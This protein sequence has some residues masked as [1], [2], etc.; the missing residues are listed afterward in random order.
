M[1]QE[2]NKPF[3]FDVAPVQETPV[4]AEPKRSKSMSVSGFAENALQDAYDQL[5]GIFQLVPTIVGEGVSIGKDAKWLSKVK[6]EGVGEGVKESGKAMGK[7]I[8]EPYETHGLRVLYEK[9][10]TAVSDALAVWG[11]TAKSA[12]LAGRMAGGVV[13]AKPLTLADKVVTMAKTIEELPSTLARKGIDKGVLKAS[14]GKWD[15]AKRREFLHLKAEEMAQ[16]PLKIKAD[17]ENVGKAIEALDDGEAALFHKWRVQGAPAADVAANPK[18]GQALESWRGLVTEFQEHLKKRGLLNDAQIAH[19]LEKK[20]AAEVFS[21]ID[22]ATLAE[23]RAAITKAE[24]KPVYGPSL[25]DKKGW[26][27]DDYVDEILDAQKKNKGGAVGFLEEYKGKEGSIMDPRKYIPKHIATFRHV[28]GKLRFRDRLLQTPEL[29]GAPKGTKPMEGAAPPGDISKRY[30][31]DQLRWE[32]ASEKFTDPTIKRL[33]QLEANHPQG[34][35]RSFLRVYD[36]I[37]D[38]FRKSATVMNPRW[39]LGNAVG[40]AV[41]GTLAGSEWRQAQKLAARGSLP[42]Q[43]AAKIGPSGDVSGAG[44]FLEKASEIGNSADQATKAGVVT[45]HVAQKLKETGVSAEASFETLENVLKSTQQF[46]DVQVEMQLLQEQIARGSDKVRRVNAVIDNYAKKHDDAI[47]RA[48]NAGRKGDKALMEQIHAEDIQPL[49]QKIENLQAFKDAMVRDVADDLAKQGVL[50]AKIPGLREQNA[51]VREAVERANAFLGDYLALDGFEQGVMRRLIPFY[52]WSKA[53]TMLAFRLPF[54]APVKGFLWN[55][56]S[57]AMWSMVGDPELPEWMHGSVP[58]FARENGDQVWLKLSS[59]SPFSGLRVSKVGGV[60]V[61][62]A[63]NLAESSPLFSVMFKTHGGKTVFDKGTMPYAGED[64]IFM[65]DGTAFQWNG[66]GGVEK[67]I[68]QAPLISSLAH[69]FPIVQYMEELVLPFKINKYG[70]HGLPTPTYNADGS[71]RYPREWWERL[72]GAAGVNLQ[73]RSRESIIRSKKMME[74]Q[75]LDN[76]KRAFAKA[77]PEER[78][79]IRETIR[80]YMN[81]R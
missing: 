7:A 34:P 1:T 4:P 12:G 20:F 38:L 48:R 45:K 51:I 56:Y 80:D 30:Y 33:L 31:E 6:W 49:R 53:M 23:A 2:Q 32:Q 17:M 69:S 36:R 52:A 58:L 61:P 43:V 76:A 18:V 70:W 62:A 71:Y 8:V 22:D 15:L 25:F 16:V 9:P 59:Y 66:K 77:S 63:M 50:E 13:R 75:F 55:R 60:P 24:V 29:T 44:G 42:P 37:L 47:T 26:T 81:Q 3:Q 46:S 14:G 28:E 72:A 40:D 41:L 79:A 35:L 73:A 19:V 54:L 57:Q 65:G 21:K 10:V 39:Y 68:S 27:I 78:V 11:L 74:K 5:K 67:T 64:L